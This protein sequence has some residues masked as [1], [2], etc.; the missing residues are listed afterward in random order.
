MNSQYNLVVQPG[1]CG[2][3]GTGDVTGV[4]AGVEATASDNG[5]PTPTHRLLSSSPALDSGDP[6]GC[7]DPAGKVLEFDQRG[8]GFPRVRGAFCD[9]GAYESTPFVDLILTDGFED[10]IVPE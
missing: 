2:F 7:A 4:P 9:K 8:A 10:P 3:T 1:S 5:G 6:A